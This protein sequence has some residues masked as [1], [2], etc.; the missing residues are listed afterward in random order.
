MSRIKRVLIS[1]SNKENLKPIL[2]IFKKYNIEILS[3]G[4]TYKKIKNLK[5]KATEISDFTNLVSQSCV[6]SQD[7]H[8]YL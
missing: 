2:N 8:Y 1:I 3:S 6:T 4:G 5:F 7:I